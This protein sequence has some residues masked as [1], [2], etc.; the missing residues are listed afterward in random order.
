MY[1]CQLWRRPDVWPKRLNWLKELGDKQP[2]IY[3]MIFHQCYI[4]T[5]RLHALSLNLLLFVYQ[6]ESLYIFFLWASVYNNFHTTWT[7][8]RDYISTYVY[9]YISSS[10]LSTRS[11]TYGKLRCNISH[12]SPTQCL[13]FKGAVRQWN[14]FHLKDLHLPYNQIQSGRC[15]NIFGIT[16]RTIL[17]LQILVGFIMSA[18]A[19]MLYFHPISYSWPRSTDSRCYW[20]TQ[21]RERISSTRASDEQQQHIAESGKAVANQWCQ[22]WCLWHKIIVTWYTVP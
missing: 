1:Y 10:I 19:C 8:I 20:C 7:H 3:W 9:N 11:S 12:A 6:Y 22:H 13:Y 15:R 17:I 18:H 4:K 21:P 14:S 16:W 5:Y 2:N